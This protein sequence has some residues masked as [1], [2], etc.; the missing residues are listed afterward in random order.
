VIMFTAHSRELIEA[1]MGVTERSK[2]AGFAGFL[3]KPFDLNVLVETVARAIE[4]PI[5]ARLDRRF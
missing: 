2:H 5:G 4:N 1:Q 3:S